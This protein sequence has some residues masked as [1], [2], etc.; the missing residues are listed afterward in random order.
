MPAM[1][2]ML[3]KP[4]TLFKPD[5][6]QNDLLGALSAA[7]WARLSGELEYVELAR[8]HELHAQGH[9]MSHAYFPV[10][11]VVS[12]VYVMQSGASAEMAAIGREGVVG[13]ALFMGGNT[14]PS[15][16]VVQTA[17]HAFRLRAQVLRDEFERAGTVMHVLLRYTQ[18]L[19]TEMAMLGACNRHH[20]LDHRLCRWLLR[21]TDRLQGHDVTMTQEALAEKLGVRRE[22]VTE[23]ALKLRDA[24]L[25]TYAR[26]HISVLDR[27]GLERRACECHDVVTKEY[28]R[29][30]PSRQVC[31]VAGQAR[32]KQKASA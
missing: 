26:G 8:G 12:L 19:I 13:I 1:P 24:G 2:A 9:S 11:A 25:I 20:S 10:T 27:P 23:S 14:M 16:A 30:L 32:V 5:A 15:R 3:V 6:R 28:A 21:Y 4:A 7:D 29:L 18:A 22:G 31:H 17:G